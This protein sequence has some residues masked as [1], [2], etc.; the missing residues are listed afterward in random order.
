[1]LTVTVNGIGTAQQANT[2]SLAKNKLYLYNGNTMLCEADVNADGTGGTLT[3][4]TTNKGL[5]IG[6]NTLTVAHGG[7]DNLL[8][9]QS[10]GM[11]T[12]T[13]K[14]A[15]LT[16]GTVTE[17][18]K[19][20][21]VT[22]TVATPDGVQNGDDVS[23]DVTTTGKDVGSYSIADEKLTFSLT[24]IGSAFYEV[25]AGTLEITKAQLKTTAAT[26]AE[27]NYD[28]TTTATVTGVTLNGLAADEKLELG[29]DYTATAVFTD[30]AIDAGKTVNVAVT[31]IDTAVANNYEAP[32]MFIKTDGEILKATLP[33]ILNGSAIVQKNTEGFKTTVDLT[34]I[35]GLGAPP[36]GQ[37]LAFTV[38]KETWAGL[39]SA[40][41]NGGILTLT[42]KSAD[43]VTG[44]DTV[45]VTVSNMQNYVNSVITVTVNYTDKPV[46][47]IGGVKVANKT[48]DGTS[49]SYDNSG[50]Q[51][52]E[53]L[54]NKPFNTGKLLYAWYDSNNAKLAE[55]PKNV[56]SYSLK[57]SVPEN[58][59]DYMG[60]LIIPVTIEKATVTVKANDKSIRMNK[61]IP[62]L[63]DKDY[64]ITGLASKD[65]AKVTLSYDGG[66]PT[67]KEAKSVKINVV[68]TLTNS[69][70]YELN[71]VPGTLYIR[72]A[73]AILFGNERWADDT[74][75][76]TFYYSNSGATFSLTGTS[77]DVTAEYILS[78][79]AIDDPKTATGWESYSEAVPIGNN[80]YI[81][82]KF[83]PK[84]GEVYYITSPKLELIDTTPA[85]EGLID[86]AIYC[87]APIITVK[88]I[89]IAKGDT[90]TVNGT[91]VELSDNG[92]YQLKP[93][94]KQTITATNRAGKSVSRI[95]TVNNDHDFAIETV[96]STCVN[97]GIVKK[98]C[99]VCGLVETTGTDA[100]GHDWID[101][102]EGAS[103]TKPG[104]EFKLC[105][106]CGAVTD[107]KE[108]KAEG[109][110]PS[111][112]WKSDSVN[113]W[114]TCSVCSVTLD[115]QK[116]TE[117]DWVKAGDK[118]EKKECTV[119][120]ARIVERAV[121]DDA[122]S[123]GVNTF[124]KQ[125][126]VAPGAP[127]TTVESTATELWEA[128]KTNLTEVRP[129][130]NEMALDVNITLKLDVNPLEEN[131]VDDKVL[132]AIEAIKAKA[133]KPADP[134]EKESN[135]KF[136]D[137]SLNA[138][139]SVEGI[140][141]N[142]EKVT[143]TASKL[144]I[145]ISV[146]KEMYENIS[147]DIDR[148]FSMM[149][150]HSGVAKSLSG[151]YDK[152]NH[153]FTFNTNEFSTY[154]LVYT[155]SKKEQPP[156]IDSGDDNSD[157]I[158]DNKDDVQQPSQSGGSNNADRY[159]SSGNYG[160][161]G[162]GSSYVGSVT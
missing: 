59:P 33:A 160:G 3:Y 73:G 2:F 64:T 30:P 66:T 68:A 116:H 48:Y 131:K 34:K 99:K 154:A 52:Y 121:L 56:G 47:K 18:Y 43:D 75:K 45:H 79:N 130:D 106:T 23:A 123:V 10:I 133:P 141:T 28:G 134:D 132:E 152:K 80:S 139:K 118:I 136:I 53:L 22:K 124:E 61:P 69:A 153:T 102:S 36:V 97:K 87:E 85:I 144:T 146:P 77:T 95:V 127:E 138:T 82:V 78:A 44:P 62:T 19:G 149:Y 142:Q 31:L 83:T 157:D 13:L 137:I 147:D 122:E 49:L 65:E 117:S 41:V 143:Q 98:T 96:K 156:V 93:I 115:M 155:D 42:A 11:V 100:A 25:T 105:K 4:D 120:H 84:T 38:Q 92:K 71:L 140:P 91:K 76:G 88:Y 16:I 135:L 40:E 103:C 159:V 35:P 81:T 107:Y 27:K 67:G 151:D 54:D 58:D 5:D 129:Q 29:T 128:V 158:N 21:N 26:L 111:A 15:P 126:E 63:T 145:T 60:E 104:K 1:M 162:G 112:D 72:Q 57:V 12:V 50:V 119:C 7:S 109:H 32:E 14:K 70:N 108:I 9:N 20:A 161:S 150:Y 110:K 94:G 39:S 51:V 101:Q 114:H 6:E 74:Q 24:G 46:L 17:P 89:D 37:N 125:I 113:H 90:I 148:T 86:D 8:E 55:A